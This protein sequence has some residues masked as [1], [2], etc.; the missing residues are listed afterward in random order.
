MMFAASF[1]SLLLFASEPPQILGPSYPLGTRFTP[2]RWFPFAVK[3]KASTE[4][5]GRLRIQAKVGGPVFE[6]TV[7]LKEGEEKEIWMPILLEESVQEIAVD[8]DESE[9]KFP[10][11]LVRKE[12][13]LLL[14]GNA[15]TISQM[16]SELAKD[17]PGWEG[18]AAALETVN[19][20][21]PAALPLDLYF[22]DAVDLIYVQEDALDSLNIE[23]KD[24]LLRFATLRGRVWT[25]TKGKEKWNLPVGLSSL[26]EIPGEASRLSPLR[27]SIP[28][29]KPVLRSFDFARVGDVAFL[30]LCVYLG[31]AL[32][33]FFQKN[34][35]K[36]GSRLALLA[37]VATV[38]QALPWT[39]WS[40]KCPPWRVVIAHGQSQALLIEDHFEPEKKR[41]EAKLSEHL[42]LPSASSLVRV[43]WDDPFRFVRLDREVKLQTM[44]FAKD[45]AIE[46]GPGSVLRNRFAPLESLSWAL[47]P[48]SLIGFEKRWEVGEILNPVEKNSFEQRANPL[49][50][51]RDFQLA[52]WTQGEWLSARIRS[53]S[54]VESWRPHGLSPESEFL[55]W[56]P[57]R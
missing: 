10:A 6:K 45:R 49:R 37:G 50:P 46:M 3:L 25:S 16:K 57:A 48:S 23:T 17:F 44:V 29:P 11:P 56:F 34:K 27:F 5:E 12:P 24:L 15:A 33:F 8:A 14:L 36:T 2:Q 30:S 13:V 54:P 55:L 21:E 19:W 39:S 7:Q 53:Q 28:D 51:L 47:E 40:Q 32:F 42:L 1:L 22:L 35:E 43:N 41:F 31:V 18:N 38:I 9:A 4:W 20:L 52:D 26:I